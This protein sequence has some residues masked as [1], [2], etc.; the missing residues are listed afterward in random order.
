MVIPS[1]GDTHVLPTPGV[2]AEVGD[3]GAG[4][5][6]GAGVDGVQP[7]VAVAKHT[8]AVSKPV[9]LIQRIR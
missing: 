9:R 3:R 8:T 5:A 4:I 2:G 1:A 7:L 6:D